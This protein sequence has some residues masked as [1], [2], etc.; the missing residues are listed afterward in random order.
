VLYERR[1]SALEVVPY[2]EHRRLV[3]PVIGGAKLT[4]GAERI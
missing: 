1:E 4:Q 3:A 2:L